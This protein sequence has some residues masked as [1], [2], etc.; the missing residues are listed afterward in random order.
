M[1]QRIKEDWEGFLMI[2]WL[3]RTF[4]N[5]FLQRLKQTKYPKN[6]RTFHLKY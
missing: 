2:E 5:V 4:S 1:N 3:G 6:R